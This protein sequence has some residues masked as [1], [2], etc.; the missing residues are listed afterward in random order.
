MNLRK[1]LLEFR[2]STKRSALP[3]C[4]GKIIGIIK[5]IREG[6]IHELNLKIKENGYSKHI[7]REVVTRKFDEL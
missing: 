7:V 3:E 6:L 1:V 5:N 4:E 2:D